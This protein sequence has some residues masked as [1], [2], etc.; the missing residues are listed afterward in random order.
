MAA[1]KRYRLKGIRQLSPD[2]KA[3]TLEPLD[4]PI[5]YEPG[6]FAFLHILDE[7]GK[8]VLKRPY[9]IASI[10]EDK[11]LEFC[12]KLVSGQM[13][14][15]LGEMEGGQILG[16]ERGGGHFGYEGQKKAAF[17]AGGTGIAPV[18]SILRSIARSKAKGEFVFFY[19]VRNQDSI[20]YR[21]ELADLEAR[22]P[23]IKVVITLT[24][25]E[26]DGERGRVCHSM[27]RR[28]LPDARDYHFWICGPMGLIKKMRE[29]LE[30][31]GI[32][33]KDMKME[34]WG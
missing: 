12:I 1:I 26:W 5:E 25:E 17:I 16:V 29:C 4:G 22:H 20:L 14:G 21:K 19:S 6:Q 7:R 9:S 30:S 3:F 27:I 18:L 2:T 8:S 34:G 24:R 11:D 10:P 31:L 13:T 15:K 32:D 33:P 23:S 28:Y